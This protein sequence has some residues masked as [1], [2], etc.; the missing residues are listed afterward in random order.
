VELKAILC[1]AADFDDGRLYA[2]GGFGSEQLYGPRS[3]SAGAVAGVLFD[4]P[5]AQR[6]KRVR[7]SAQLG[8]T[9]GFRGD[10]WK[11]LKPGGKPV[12]A[13]RSIALERPATGFVLDLPAADLGRGANA[14][15]L[16]VAGYDLLLPTHWEVENGGDLDVTPES[17]LLLCDAA[18]VSGGR[19]QLFGA[20]SETAMP[21]GE[22]GRWALAGRLT[23]PSSR[24]VKVER[25]EIEAKLSA[26]GVDVPGAAVQ[27][28]L[29]VR[30]PAAAR[31]DLI[32]V[33]VPL[34]LPLPSIRLDAGDYGWTVVAGG[35]MVEF[36]TFK[37]G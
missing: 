23:V 30:R 35:D 32:F 26:K 4:V 20:R 36:L 8:T 19:L 29:E 17:S 24:G 3:G 34:A 6:G 13:A 16:K 9:D 14:W 21:A 10:S 31:G 15:R 33:D 18:V 27:Q 11:P 1:R 2:L 37:V 7:V 22:T 28:T 25:W 5:A 12:Q